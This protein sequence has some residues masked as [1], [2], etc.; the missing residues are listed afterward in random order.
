MNTVLAVLYY[1]AICTLAVVATFHQIQQDMAIT[2]F[3][4]FTTALWPCALGVV[5]G[6]LFIPKK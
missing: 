2:L 5:A 6:G 4:L 3:E 1:L